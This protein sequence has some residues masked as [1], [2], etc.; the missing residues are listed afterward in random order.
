M[1]SRDTRLSQTASKDQSRRLISQ[2]DLE[3]MIS[4]LESHKYDDRIIGQVIRRV[5]NRCTVGSDQDVLVSASR[6]S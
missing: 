5:V 2:P 3:A 6:L 1:R 4:Y